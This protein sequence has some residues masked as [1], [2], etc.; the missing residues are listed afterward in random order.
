[1]QRAFSLVSFVSFVVIRCCS[2]LVAAIL[3][4]SRIRVVHRRAARA[5]ALDAGVL[6][7]RSSY[8]RIGTG[9]AVARSFQR[10]VCQPP[11][12]IAFDLLA[13]SGARIELVHQP[14]GARSQAARHFLAGGVGQLSQRGLVLGLVERRVRETVLAM[15]R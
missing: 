4:E 12:E 14:R 8:G 1:R 2:K 3:A 9:M 10:R 7:G 15:M 11:F 13:V 5:G 6:V